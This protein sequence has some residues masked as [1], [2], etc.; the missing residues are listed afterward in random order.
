[1]SA[2][3]QVTLGEIRDLLK[4]VRRRGKQLSARCPAH[5]DQHNSLSVTE[6]DNGRILVHC[7]AGCSAE[8]IFASLGLDMTRALSPRK[9]II[10]E[11]S[12]RDEN[13]EELHQTVRYEP[14]DFRQRRR[15]EKGEYVWNLK[16][17]RRVPF[18]LPELLAAKKGSTIVIVEGEKDVENLRARGLLATTCSG[19]VGKWRDE[20]NPSLSEQNV[21]ILPDNDAAGRRHAEEVAASVY[22]V[23]ASVKLVELPSLA[24]KG[25][26][27]D[28]LDAGHSVEELLSL[29][30][31]SP[32]WN[33]PGVKDPPERQ[34]K[35]VPATQV[36]FPELLPKALYGLAGLIVQTIAPHTEAHP[37]ALLIQ[38][39]V[40]FGNCIG[41]TAYWTTGATRHYLVLFAVIVGESSR[42]RKGTSWDYI[43]RLF[44]G[45]DEQW[46]KNSIQSGL[47]SGEGLI[48]AVRDPVIKSVPVKKNGL[49][50]DYQNEIVDVGVAD[51]RLLVIEEEFAKVLRVIARQGNTLS[52]QVRQAWDKGNLS[53]MTKNSPLRA[54]DAHISIIGHITKDELRRN[55][56]EV[57][58]ANGFA[59][60]FLWT[61]SQRLRLLPDGGNLSDSQLNS[62]ISLVHDRV[63]FARNVREMS[64]DEEAV[65]LW[66]KVYGELSTEGRTGLFDAVTSRS[67]AQVRRMACLYAL[68]DRSGIVRRV[69][70][71][72]AL[73]LWRYCEDSARFIFGDST[74][75]RVADSVHAALREAGEQGFTKTEISN[76]LARNVSAARI[77]D[78][79]ATLESAGKAR[80]AMEDAGNGRPAQR[81][82]AAS[83]NPFSYERNEIDEAIDRAIEENSELNSLISFN[84]SSG[85]SSEAGE[86]ELDELPF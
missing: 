85:S 36:A 46:S 58:T 18:G 30:A 7:F 39:L 71:E 38:F 15:N 63:S 25:D 3:A 12:Y 28:W 51:K 84:S 42:G 1:M 52:P 56:D 32:E 66:H 13:G 34:S 76:L 49:I 50:I 59:N 27:S 53:V 14:K 64:R 65:E 67:E 22:K 35:D 20:Y 10:A 17:V 62:L 78:A 24:P 82:F 61:C 81:W 4:N 47:S 77:N 72:A 74:G 2:L 79:L 54:T 9:K 19:G 5:D 80:S 8:S 43:L 57:E 23:S 37:A 21:V 83:V 75:D 6:A 31:A 48:Y 26:V 45:V 60:R 33:P 68:L 70:L 41:R 73:A 29:I 55:L 69:H 86:K 11:Y 16:G 44:Q 40:A